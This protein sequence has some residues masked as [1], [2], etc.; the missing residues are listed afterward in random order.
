[1]AGTLAILGAGG[2]GREMYWH[3]KGADPDARIVFVDDA[4]EARVL[5]MGDA[6]VPVV[7]DWRFDA[8]Q[9]EGG[10]LG[11]ARVEEF[12]IGVGGP[13]LKRT[14]VMKA[15]ASGLL[16]APTVVHPRALIQGTD[17]ELGLGGVV[18]PGCVITTN[19]SVGDFVVLNLNTSVGH[20]CV[21]GD[22]V[23]CNPGCQI[24][25][26]VTIGEGASLGTGTVVREGITIA[27]GV[28]TGAQACVVKDVTAP[29][30]MVAGVPAQ[31][32]R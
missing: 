16:P 22:Y 14:L 3:V 11:A 7:Q 8:V 1:M 21:I 19:V 32:L 17:C 26:N 15:L 27:P 31:E 28:V 18:T 24:S 25:G 10:S 29:D 5:V 12:V 9:F 20:D 6:A 4:A 23:T 2:F 13:Q 30:V